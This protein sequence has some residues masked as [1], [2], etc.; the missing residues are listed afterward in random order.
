MHKSAADSLLFVYEGIRAVDTRKYVRSCIS[1]TAD[2]LVYL[3]A[4]PRLEF[5]D[6][7]RTSALQRG[8]LQRLARHFRLQVT[9]HPNCRHTDQLEALPFRSD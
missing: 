8:A 5:L 6:I 3:E 4:L 1:A 7:R 2:G 9:L